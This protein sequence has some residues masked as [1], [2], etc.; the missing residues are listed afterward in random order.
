MIGESMYHKIKSMSDDYSLRIISKETGASVNTIRKYKE[1][2][3]TEASN[4][5]GK[6][7]RRSQFDIAFDYIKEQYGY[8]PYISIVKLHSNIQRQYPGITGSVSALE[9]YLKSH[10]IFPEKRIRIYAPVIDK[11]DGGQVQVDMGEANVEFEGIGYKKVY[12][13]TTDRLNF[14]SV[15]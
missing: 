3:L 14:I 2:G 7:K 1:I 10:N 8:Y 6:L 9:K 15:S 5:I 11:V 4:Y 13:I 12:F